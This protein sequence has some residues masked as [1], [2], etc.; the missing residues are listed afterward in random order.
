MSFPTINYSRKIRCI[1]C[2]EGEENCNTNHIGKLY[3]TSTSGSLFSGL[4]GSKHVYSSEL[5][6]NIMDNVKGVGNIKK[7]GSGGN[8]YNSYLL[9]KKGIVNCNCAISK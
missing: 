2:P 7:L 9:R 8:S 3:N 4:I 1:D 6:H 5:S